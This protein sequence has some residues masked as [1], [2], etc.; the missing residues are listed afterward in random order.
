M[1][2]TA[3]IY[4]TLLQHGYK[5]TPPREKVIKA[6][7]RF[8]GLFSTNDIIKKTTT[9]DRVSV[10]RTI[11][12]LSALDI[13]HPVTLRD[14]EQ[15]YELHA[16]KKHAHH[17]VCHDCNKT[18]KIACSIPNIVLKGFHHIHHTL[19]LSGLCS[20]CAKRAS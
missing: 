9:V 17:V 11:E 13:I 4:E 2:S 8:N 10:Y 5:Q 18:T 3:W 15:V 1:S 7:T 20:R 12:L 16:D 14:G 19:V 6:I